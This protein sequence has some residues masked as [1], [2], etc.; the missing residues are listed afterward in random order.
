MWNLTRNWNLAGKIVRTV[1]C[2]K[3]KIIKEMKPEKLISQSLQVKRHRN[4]SDLVWLSHDE[5]QTVSLTHLYQLSRLLPLSGLIKINATLSAL[6]G[7]LE[8]MRLQP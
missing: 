1:R 4:E 8:F 7:Y 6:N 5:L 3:L 2:F